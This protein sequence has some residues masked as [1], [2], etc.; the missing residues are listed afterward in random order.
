HD[1]MGPMA[2]VYEGWA[3]WLALAGVEG[4]DP[5]AGP[6]FSH[7]L[8]LI[9]AAINGMGVALAP[10]FM[11]TNDLAAGRLVRPFD[12]NMPTRIDFWSVCP[13]G[14]ADRPKVRIYREW[15]DEIAAK[16]K[17]ATSNPSLEVLTEAVGKSRK[18]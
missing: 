9:E 13:E 1:E 6:R 14:T 7:T 5:T 4:I 16:Y 11:I 18:K 10:L 3:G 17:N 2:H 12:I 8:M 15:L